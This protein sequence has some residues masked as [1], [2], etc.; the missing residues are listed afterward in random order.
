MAYANRGELKTAYRTWLGEQNQDVLPDGVLEDAIG[1]VENNLDWGVWGPFNKQFRLLQM[2]AVK[3]ATITADDEEYVDLPEDFISMRYVYLPNDST[4][5][6]LEYRDPLD[7]ISTSESLPASRRVYTIS[8]GQI[9]VKPVLQSGDVLEMG[10][11]QQIPALDS[12]TAS[13]WLLAQNPQIYLYGGLVHIMTDGVQGGTQNLATVTM[14]Y[15]NAV[16]GAIMADGQRETG[17]GPLTY[18]QH[19]EPA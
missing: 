14:G 17:E 4:K 10:Y 8:A 7:F 16:L 18:G 13:N 15:E 19:K 1:F 9:R 12:D 2:Q 5:R 6:A 3:R 11:Y